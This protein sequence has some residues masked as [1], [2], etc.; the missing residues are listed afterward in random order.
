MKKDQD[1]IERLAFHL[2]TYRDVALN[3]ANNGLTSEQLSFPIEKYLGEFKVDLYSNRIPS[4]LGNPKD[5]VHLSRRP[6]VLLTSSGAQGLY[7]FGLLVCK[8]KIIS[9]I[10]RFNSEKNNLRYFWAKV[11]LQ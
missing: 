11:M 4:F 8:V 9:K 3:V 5:G 10:E 2:I 1:P 7:R 6:D